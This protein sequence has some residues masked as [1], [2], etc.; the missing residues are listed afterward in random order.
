MP[1]QTE[2]WVVPLS[3]QSRWFTRLDW[4]FNWQLC[5]G[6]AH[7]TRVIGPELQRIAGELG[8]ATANMPERPAAP[9]LVGC[10]GMVPAA[11]CLVLPFE[12]SLKKWLEEI[13]E[14]AA[15]LSVRQAQIF[16]P[17]DADR[18]K[19]E[20]AWAKIPGECSAVFMVD[21]EEKR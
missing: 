10:N 8:V 18:E 1:P 7:R 19:A 12:K 20:E 6:L 2:L 13:K 17:S 3:D 9:L 4:Y 16:L 5:K 11:K 15:G 14:I 21:L